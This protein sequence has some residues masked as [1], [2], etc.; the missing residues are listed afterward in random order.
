MN[1]NVGGVIGGLAGAAAG[2]ALAFTLI[3]PESESQRGIGKLVMF[4]VVGG[5][6]VGNFLWGLVGGSAAGGKD[7][8]E[9]AAADDDL[10]NAA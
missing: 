1:L 5:A 10:R 3:G 2:F 8:A 7:N 9:S 4:G 6:F